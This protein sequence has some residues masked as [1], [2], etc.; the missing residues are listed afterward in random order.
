MQAAVGMVILRSM[1]TCP[2]IGLSFR[3][4]LH[5]ITWPLNNRNPCQCA[6]QFVFVVS[7]QGT[8]EVRRKGIRVVYINEYMERSSHSSCLHQAVGLHVL[9]ELPKVSMRG[10]RRSYSI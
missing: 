9:G 2:T 1:S 8:C 4:L 5:S 3:R 10:Q 7:K 6:Y